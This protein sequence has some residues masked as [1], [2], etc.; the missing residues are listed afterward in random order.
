VLLSIAFW[1]VTIPLA[2]I[3][4]LWRPNRLSQKLNQ[5]A[6]IIATIA[7]VLIFAILGGAN[8][9]ANRAPSLTVTEPNDGFSIQADSATVKGS[10]SPAD[11][12]VTIQDKPVV[13]DENGNFSSEVK[14]DN[15]SNSIAIEAKSGSKTV[16]RT[17]SV[18]RIFTE[19]EKAE[20]ERLTKE[21]A[22]RETK[23]KEEDDKRHAEEAAQA[24]VEFEEQQR[25]KQFEDQFSA[26]DGSHRELTKIIKASMND[27]DSYEHVETVYWDRDDHLIVSTTF[28]GKNAFGGT[29]VNTVKAKVSLDGQ[30]IEIIE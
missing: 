19:E 5:K 7:T 23:Q 13:V 20:R 25:K 24:R 2:I 10:V 6:K 30:N 21:T 16:K 1:Y 4:F 26:W 12:T 9:Y 22:E 18:S 3:W 17:L 14:L 28:R 15:E 29:V 8:M 27:P 11:A